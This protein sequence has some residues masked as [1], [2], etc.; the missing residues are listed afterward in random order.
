MEHQNATKEIDETNGINETNELNEIVT[1]VGRIAANTEFNDIKL[2]DGNNPTLAVQVGPNNSANDRI[3]M[4]FGDLQTSTLGINSLSLSS[5]S[6]ASA[7]ITTIDTALD[8]ISGY[9][10]QYGATQNRLDSNVANMETYRSNLRSSHSSIMDADYAFESAQFSKY[11]TQQ[12]A[13]IA[14]MAQANLNRQAIL[15]LLG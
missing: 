15:K 5:T 2:T 7:A 14:V 8:S 1:E 4:T 3:S 6:S 10:S 11:Q 9:A 12:Q 13:A